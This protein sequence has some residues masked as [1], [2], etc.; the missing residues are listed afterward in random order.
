MLARSRATKFRRGVFTT[1][2]GRWPRALARL[3]IPLPVIEKILAHSSGTFAGIV[4]VYQLHSF[5]AEKAEA[6]EKWGNAVEKF[7][8]GEIE[9]RT[10]DTSSNASPARKRG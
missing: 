9:N 7:V 8:S 2:G 10:R 4:G 6:L 5:A 1:C 3:K